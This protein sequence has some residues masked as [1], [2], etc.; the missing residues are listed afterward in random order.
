MLMVQATNFREFH[1]VA[2]F[3]RM[4]GT[5]D[6]AILVQGQV[7][8]CL[9]VVVEVW[10][11]DAPQMPMVEDYNVVEAVPPYGPYSALHL[12]VLPG[13]TWC[14]FHLLN[15]KFQEFSV[16]TCRAPGGVGGDHLIDEVTQVLRYAGPA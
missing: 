3:G 7:C 6:G 5:G 12:W 16:H 13:V 8:S 9:V 2:H 15:A 4:D 10:P 11:K 1:N 14:R